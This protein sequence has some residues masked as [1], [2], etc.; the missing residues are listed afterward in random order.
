MRNRQLKNVS[1]VASWQLCSGCGV[2]VPACSQKAVSLIDVF[3]HG[4]RPKVDLTKCQ[5]CSEC[6]KVC[7]GIGLTH[8]RFDEAT[9]P[10]LRKS[11]GPV[12][13]VWEGYA[14]DP[15]IRFKGSSGG[16]ATALALYCLEKENIAGALHIGANPEQ[17][18]SNISVFSQNRNDLL[19]CTGSRYS[20][21]AP[22]EKLDMIKE[23]GG[24]CVFLGKPCDVAALRKMQMLELGINKNVGLAISIF[25]AGTPSTE[26]TYKLLDKL[27]VKPNEVKEIRYRGCGWPGM[28]SVI[29]N[30][31][32]QEKRQITYEESW[33]NILCHYVQFRC[34]ICPDATGEFADI[35]CGD[36]WYRD[37]NESCEGYSLVLA[38]TELGCQ[39]I[40]AAIHDGYLYLTKRE[41]GV[42]PASQVSLLNKRRNI[43]GRLIAMR[44]FSLP[45]PDFDGFSLVDNFKCLCIVEKAKSI[46]GTIK[47]IVMRRPWRI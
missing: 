25:C 26:G 33:G 22:C 16:V 12:L 27:S 9:I 11:W 30:R 21:A 31:D 44:L 45:T 13:E 34:R 5:E 43:Y 47:R 7:P 10:Q 20:P 14:T 8:S 19:Q 46:F 3:D 4:I 42:V 18:L 38:R 24:M 36:P 6:L 29:L 23:A 28:T 2:C 1:D 32:T 15:E 35:S 40:K 37:N 39:L 17:P 41:S